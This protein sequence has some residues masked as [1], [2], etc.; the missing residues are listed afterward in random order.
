MEQ[1]SS[2]LMILGATGS[3]GLQTLDVVRSTPHHYQ[4]FALTAH[5]DIQTL[6]EQCAEF[7]PE[8]AVLTDSTHLTQL[9]TLLQQKQ[10][11]TKACAQTE[12]IGLIKESDYDTLVAGMSGA[13]GLLPTLAAAQAGKRILL[14]NKEALVVAGQLLIETAQQNSAKLLPLDSEH[15][16]IFQ[17]LGDAT[18]VG[19]HVR[20]IVLTAS[21]GPF[22]H[23][24]LEQLPTVSPEQACAHPIWTMGDKISVD[25]ATLMN[26]GLEVIEAHWLFQL[27]PERIDVVIHPQSIVHGL[28][29]MSDGSVLAQMATPDMRLPISYALAWPKRTSSPA[30][31]L[32]LTQYASLEFQEVEAQRFPCLT[33]AYQALEV[34]A[35]APIVLNAANE[36]AVQAFLQRQ[37]PFDAIAKLCSQ[38]METSHFEA[39]GDLASIVEIDKRAR[40][41]AKAQITR[42][43]MAK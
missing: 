26:K 23:L 8:Y 9:E 28:V 32:D 15:N 14:A 7:K 31:R 6:V 1:S 3:I 40:L 36:E 34:A 24:P 37:I 16:A 4:I 41:D 18:A 22:L 42:L 10:L 21:G 38:I 39:V 2:K 29:E 25:S 27:E 13:A 43:G 12:L 19:Q 30:E 33:L 20:R 11:A 17:C 35:S 5:H